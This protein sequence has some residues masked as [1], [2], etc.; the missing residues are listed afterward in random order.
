MSAE[1]GHHWIPV[2]DLMSGVVGVAIIM[3][4]VALHK[5]ETEDAARVVEREQR[6]AEEME[7][8]RRSLTGALQGLA[9]RV[10][11][12]DDLA[13]AL[14][15]LPEKGSITLRQGTFEEASACLMAP[16]EAALA[17]AGLQLLDLLAKDP[18]YTLLIEGH[19][20]RQRLAIPNISRNRCGPFDD[21]LML[22]TARAREARRAIVVGWPDE[23]AQRV[24]IAGFGDSKPLTGSDD[25]PESQA[26]NRRVEISVRKDEVTSEG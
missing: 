23:L 25:T 5:Q 12:D 22:S 15:V 16:V 1:S 19:S 14:T 24:R 3:L 8:R 10:E 2:A 26:R 13:M 11:E 9:R 7:S 21:N 17:D 18:S 4:V 20:D 6:R